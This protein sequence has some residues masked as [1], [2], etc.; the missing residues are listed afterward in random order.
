MKKKAKI[1]LDDEGLPVLPDLFDGLVFYLYGSFST[2]ERKQIDR[3]VAT[4]N[5]KLVDYMNDSV[6]H[7]V[8]NSHEWDSGFTDALEEN[9][10]LKFVKSGWIMSCGKTMKRQP[11]EEFLL[12]LPAT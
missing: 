12:T 6:T 8:T 10:N 9:P 2:V 11:I 7:V 4:L 5:G 1:A 3:Y